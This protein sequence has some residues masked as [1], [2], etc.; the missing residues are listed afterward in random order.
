MAG[1]EIKGNSKRAN[2]RH[3]KFVSVPLPH[4]DIEKY[5]T[6]IKGGPE[7]IRRIEGSTMKVPKKKK[8]AGPQAGR[9]KG[10][11]SS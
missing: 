2:Y 3:G 10:G 11:W 9:P 8:L 5:K 7:I 1:K 4:A 6:S